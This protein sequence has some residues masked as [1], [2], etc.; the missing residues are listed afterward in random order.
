MQL[1]V[2]PTNSE[3]AWQNEGAP[4]IDQRVSTREKLPCLACR[5][6]FVRFFLSLP[7]GFALHAYS[8]PWQKRWFCV[9]QR[10]RPREG[11]LARGSPRREEELRMAQKKGRISGG[12]SHP[13]GVKD[14]S[15]GERAEA[16]CKQAKSGPSELF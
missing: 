11:K 10:L 3:E 2:Q 5:G 6:P 8:T 1:I 9:S 14:C 16:P 13:N 12:V 7:K 15:E 4:S